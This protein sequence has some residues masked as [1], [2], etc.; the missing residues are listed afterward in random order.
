[1]LSSV[2]GY[3]Y[4]LDQ[5]H[6]ADRLLLWLLWGV[7]L[8]HPA[9]L[10]PLVWWALVMQGQ[11]QYPLGS[12]SLTDIRPLYEQLLLLQIYLAAH[13]ILAWLPAKLP[14][15]AR[16]QPVLPPIWALAL[17]LQAANYLVPG[18][19]KLRMGWL[20]HDGLADFWLAAY[21]YGWMASLGDE[22]ALALAAW[23]TRFNLPLLLL[24]LLVELGVILILWRRRLTLAL[25]LAMA[26][27]HVAILAFSGIFFWKWITLDLLLFYIIRRQDAGETRQL[28]ARPVVGAAFLLLLSSG[29]LFRPTPLYWYDTPLTQRFNLELVT[30]TGEVM[31][32]DRNF[33]RPFQIVFS[34]EG[35]HILN[36]EPFLVGT[37]GA[38]S[39]LAVQE[40]L[41][42]A[43]SPAD[44]RAIGA[45]LGQ[46]VV[47]EVGRRQYDAF[48]RTYFSNYNHERRFAGWI[49]PNHILV[50]TP[51][52]AY[53]GSAPVAQVRVRY[54]QT[55][56]DGQQLHVIGDEII[57]VTDI[58]AAD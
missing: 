10:G 56:Y 48:M 9:G 46:I 4:Y 13:A 16:W 22:R 18:W 37:Y 31:P 14:W 3:N 41:L 23:L 32:L 52:G 34:K 21:S 17:C 15:L 29:F 42:A 39:E 57:H 58:P 33:M 47:S 5:F 36:T 28:Y 40:A 30:T 38:V 25:L 43:R 2:Y 11:F 8:W 44:V 24:T 45:E 54:I 49:W 1:W 20:S 50:E 27:L 7:V 6:L 35:M 12:Y 26:G 51:A 55:W 19:G 53:D